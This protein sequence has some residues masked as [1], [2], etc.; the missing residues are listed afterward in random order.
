MDGLSGVRRVEGGEVGA[1]GVGGEVAGIRN[2]GGCGADDAPEFATADAVG[3]G[4][5][6]GS[7]VAEGDGV[8]EALGGVDLGDGA[9]GGNGSG[10]AGSLADGKSGGGAL[11][12]GDIGI[13]LDL[14][15]EAAD[16]ND[17]SF[18]VLV[19]GGEAGFRTWARRRWRCPALRCGGGGCGRRFR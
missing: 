6:G 3:L 4:A 18:L 7:F 1:G 14:G 19:E 16:L 2:A 9:G 12:G 10:G 8:L 5:V 15:D 13:G 17:E 11:G